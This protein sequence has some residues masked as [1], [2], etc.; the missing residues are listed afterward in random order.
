MKLIKTILAG[1]ALN[2]L[3]SLSNVCNAQQPLFDD[4]T[5]A[6]FAAFDLNEAADYLHAH[7]AMLNV[8]RRADSLLQARGKS[9]TDISDGEFRG[10]YWNLKKS[11]A[12]IAYMLGLHTEMQQVS[13]Q[14][15]DCLQRRTANE[16]DRNGF[17]ADI[18][19]ID[20]GRYYLTAHYDSAEVALRQ[21]LALKPADQ[22]FVQAVRGDL[23]QLYYVQKQ[24]DKALQQLDS[25][26]NMVS[27]DAAN[28]AKRQE[29]SSQRAIC[30]ARL[31][32]YADALSVIN[33][34]VDH[35]RQQADQRRLAEALRKKGKILMLQYD[36][37]GQFNAE[38]TACYEEY[39]RL[40]RRF[41]DEH[42]C[43]MNESERE[44]YWMAEHTFVTD[45]YRLEDK[46]PALLYD[47]ALFSK[48]VLLQLG[49]TFQ[50][51]MTAQQRAEALKAVRTTWQQ[52][53]Q[54]LGAEA[55]AL[56]FINYEKNGKQHM[57]A[58]L[59]TK[60][61]E[62]Q[63]IN[64]ASL[65]AITQHQVMLNANN[66]IKVEDLFALRGGASGDDQRINAIY[67]DSVLH[68]IVW[69]DALVRAIGN[70]NI[71]YMAA[72]GIFHRLAPEYLLPSSL[73]GRRVYR[74]TSTRQLTEARSAIRTDRM[75]MCGGVDY[76][77][78]LGQAANGN[79]E[80]AYSTIAPVLHNLD[81][82][83][84][85][86]A[87]VD[88][89]SAVRNLHTADLVL[90]SDSVTETAIRQM[91]NQYHAVLISTHG[92]FAQATQLGTDLRPASADM[93]LSQSVIFLSGAEANLQNDNFDATLSDG[94]LS[95]REVAALDL[96]NIDFAV[97]SACQ[98]GLGYITPD[99]VFGLQ[100]GLKTAGVRAIVTSLWEVNDKA[101]S[102]LMRYLYTN[103]E[104][105]MS[106]HQAFNEARTRLHDEPL[107][108][109][110][111]TFER[112][113]FFSAPY[114][115]NAFILIDALENP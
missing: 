67:N 37:T 38:S 44:Q 73:T 90:H 57:G 75:L 84:G 98:S 15:S 3:C 49:R 85:S 76:R 104:A 80:L 2:V 14:L 10:F 34:I 47:V 16:A 17:L 102:M 52:V 25:I 58:L 27:R 1:A 7:G 12:E 100:R 55:A 36:A 28:E 106:L 39:L 4:L 45:C 5:D 42:F 62:P 23:A 79:D 26:L 54:G 86:R 115:C 65:D 35:Y 77:Q 89:I 41:V 78:A 109:R 66:R 51:D 61:S 101:T 32:Q 70:S 46:A 56:E 103:L 111:G 74:L 68:T 6:Y 72:D 60:S 81:Y 105:G 108:E 22:P 91:L 63:F 11:V 53:Q 20:G 87:E 9:T 50:P 99:G 64:I 24:Y 21:A 114:F 83:P 43:A 33:N 113:Q 93:Q 69:P 59:L 107:I 48:S 92:Y 110:F 30:L 19:K 31:G 18:A 94:I 29:I 96:S 95:A 8:S 40:A 82:L 97:V 112:K 71:I 88:S 13:T